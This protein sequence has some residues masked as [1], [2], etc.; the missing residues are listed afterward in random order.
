MRRDAGRSTLTGIAAEAGVSVSTVSKVLNGRSDV[1]P[2]TRDRIT[3]LLRGRGY[4]IVPGMRFGIVDLLIGSLHGPWAEELIRGAVDA[5][6][7]VGHSI[8]VT[9]VSHGAGFTDWLERA[10]RRG[11]DGLLSV[12]YL[13]APA[14]RQRLAAAHIP[15][16][17]VDPPTEPGG[18]SQTGDIRSVGTTNWQGGLTATRHLAELGHRR[19]GAIGGPERFWSAN[20]RLDGYRTALMRSGLPVDEDLVVR[21]EFVVPAGRDLTRVLLD[22]PDPPTAIVA[23]NDNQAFGALQALGERGLRVPGDVSL[24]GFDDAIAAWATPP[25][26]TIRQP[27]GAMTAAAFRMLRMDADGVA[28]QPQHVELATELVVRESTAPPRAL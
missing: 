10:A 16:I 8:V 26:T 17:V 28:A 20:A 11:T 7:E 1:A 12:A 19:I 24:V 6:R 18:A 3:K 15:L 2:G 27:L 14:E 13:P 23:A 4:Q 25:L 5:A 21:G 9:T 22:R